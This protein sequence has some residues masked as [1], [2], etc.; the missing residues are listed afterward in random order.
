MLLWV[1]VFYPNNM[2][3]TNTVAFI[4]YFITETGKI[5]KTNIGSTFDREIRWGF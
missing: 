1:M 4:G 3:V 5:T 2:E